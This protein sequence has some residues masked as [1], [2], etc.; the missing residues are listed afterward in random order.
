VKPL[1][2]ASHLPNAYDFGVTTN[3]S[4]PAARRRRSTFAGP[5]V[6]T[7]AFLASACGSSSRPIPG[8]NPF[9]GGAAAAQIRIHIRNYNFYDATITALSDTGRRK[10][11]TVGGNQNAVFTMPWTFSGR[12][13]LEVD[14]LA[15]PTCTTEPIT[16]SPGEDVDLQ[17]QSSSGSSF[18][19]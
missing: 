16:V 10:L 19:R 2:I 1:G 17:I 15:G 12:L 13:S 14:L 6:C 18:C 7:A 9:A 11:G 8:Q 4:P 5:L 3:A